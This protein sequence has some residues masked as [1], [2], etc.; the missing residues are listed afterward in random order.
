MSLPYRKVFLLLHHT[1][2]KTSP[3][4]ML[5]RLLFVLTLA[6]LATVAVQEHAVCNWQPHRGSPELWGYTKFCRSMRGNIEDDKCSYYCLGGDIGEESTEVATW[7]QLR[8]WLVNIGETKA[9]D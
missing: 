4:T 9:C 3:T 7:G 1:P 6:L 8:D 5:P 2:P